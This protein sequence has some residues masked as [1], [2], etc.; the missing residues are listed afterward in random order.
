M[1]FIIIEDESEVGMEIYQPFDLAKTEQMIDE[2]R[3]TSTS[4]DFHK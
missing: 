2:I 4:S 1:S 3:N